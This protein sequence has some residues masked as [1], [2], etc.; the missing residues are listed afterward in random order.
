[1][2]A[3]PTII[4]GFRFLHAYSTVFVLC[5]QR[6]S[7]LGSLNLLT[8]TYIKVIRS[9]TSVVKYELFYSYTYSQRRSLRTMA[10]DLME[11]R[12]RFQNFHLI[13]HL[14]DGQD[15]TTRKSIW[16]HVPNDHGS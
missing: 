9:S 3:C 16:R 8:T 5:T 11:E 10:A 6:L 1:M 15:P 2:V 4:N 13:A 7:L 14:K 12:K